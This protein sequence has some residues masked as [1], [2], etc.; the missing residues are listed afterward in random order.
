MN[1]TSHGITNAFVLRNRRHVGIAA[2]AGLLPD[3]PYV[4]AGLLGLVTYGFSERAL[5]EVWSNPIANFL[6]QRVLQSVVLATACGV[7]ALVSRSARLRA[8]AAGWA[9]HV[10]IDHWLH[11]RDAYPT[12][13]PLSRRVFPSPISYWDW[14]YHGRWMGLALAL[15]AIALW[16]WLARRLAAR[17]RSRWK[18]LGAATALVVGAASLPTVYFAVSGRFGHST[19]PHASWVDEGFSCWPPAVEP[20]VAAIRAGDPATAIAILDA[21]PEGADAERCPGSRRWEAPIPG[22]RIALVRGYALDLLGRRDEALAAYRRAERIETVGSVGDK[23]R[24]YQGE[25]FVNEPD[26]VVSAEWIAIFV[27]GL[28]LCVL[29]VRSVPRQGGVSSAPISG[30]VP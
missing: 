6:S 24:R 13:W 22:A 14:D 27:W 10:W 28:A 8:F 2:A 18:W 12:L 7:V 19:S 21:L 29:L 23:A 3:M 15:W 25:P 9:L 16:G 5:L 17:G 26:P 11:A 4:L 20:A 1:T 30:P